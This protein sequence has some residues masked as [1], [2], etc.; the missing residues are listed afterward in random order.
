MILDSKSFLINQEESL[1]KKLMNQRP[2]LQEKTSKK[3][4][5]SFTTL[6][7]TEEEK[8]NQLKTASSSA[9]YSGTSN[10]NYEKQKTQREDKKEDHEIDQNDHKLK[11]FTKI[12]KE[13]NIQ[14]EEDEKRNQKMGT[15]PGTT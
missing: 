1:Q 10:K 8:E 13:K 15:K 3:V 2:K 9:T 4:K 11:A 6:K 5:V 14:K 12:A 7:K